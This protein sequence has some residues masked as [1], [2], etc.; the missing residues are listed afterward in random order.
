MCTRVP[1]CVCA[2]L[3][4]LCVHMCAH[5]H[6]QI[7][8]CTHLTV[9]TH[10]HQH[11]HVSMHTRVE[12]SGG[13]CP[14]KHIRESPWAPTSFQCRPLDPGSPGEVWGLGTSQVA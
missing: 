6:V 10:I 8:T 14:V 1:S 13:C 7:C 3:C 11:V 4:N 5:M 9:S 2:H 12:C